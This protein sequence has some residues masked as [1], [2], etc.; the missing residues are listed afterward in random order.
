MSLSDTD[1]R[2][3]KAQSKAVKMFDGGGLFLLISTTG[4]K[5]WRLKYRFQGKEKL[6]ALGAY[7]PLHGLFYDDRCFFYDENVEPVVAQW[8]AFQA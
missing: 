1:I 8:V 3:A 4:G 5:L 2:N 7:L 6:L